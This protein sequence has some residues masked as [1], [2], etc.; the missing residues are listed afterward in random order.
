VTQ[1]FSATRRTRAEAARPDLVRAVEEELL[2]WNPRELI[3][4]FRH[5]HRD[6]FSL[7]HLNVLTILES[8]GP[9]S[10]SRLAEALDVSVASA[11]GIVDRMETRGLVERRRDTDDRRVVV[12]HPTDRGLGVFALIDERRR[13]GLA[14]LL[15]RLSDDD[16]AALL[17]GHRALRA[18]RSAAKS[19]AEAA[20]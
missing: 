7:I 8:D 16:L 20:T 12:V 15:E 18:A 3:A 10:M 4:A 11:T 17:R 14:G 19:D 2:S 6:S 1:T 5:W 9:L 13:T